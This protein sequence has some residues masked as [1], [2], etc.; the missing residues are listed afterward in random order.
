[1]S[2]RTWVGWTW[3]GWGLA[4][5]AATSAALWA[6]AADPAPRAAVP[7]AVAR[8]ARLMALDGARPARL[9]TPMRGVRQQPF[10]GRTLWVID[11]GKMDDA[12]LCGT[13][14]CDLQFWLSRPDGGPVRI[15]DRRVLSHAID[16][17]TTPQPVV[18]VDQHG[19]LC[20]EPGNAECAVA[21]RWA[22]GAADAGG[23][24]VVEPVGGRG[25]LAGPLLAAVAPEPRRVP[26]AVG[27]ALS[28]LR[29]ECRRRGGRAEVVADELPDLDGDGRAE[30]ATGG[31]A[32]FCT[33]G[34][35]VIERPCGAAP[36]PVTIFAT[37]GG[38][39]R[40]AFRA[41]G[42]VYLL[43]YEASG[44]RLLVA[45]RAEPGE[46]PATASARALRFA[47]GGGPAR[48]AP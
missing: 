8:A 11:G 45:P 38:T 21:Y 1:M 20:G 3:M 13:G 47:P 12:S 4:G 18:R 48:P 29:G 7:P 39:V 24:L 26:A 36:C 42:I 30:W 14:G 15:L 22:P 43:S 40:R 32:L 37:A 6:D 46:R 35:R 41:T 9:V 5:F 16:G 25:V 17:A 23:R 44:V 28:D 2:G 31:E 10:A 19:S 33:R 27:A 34:D